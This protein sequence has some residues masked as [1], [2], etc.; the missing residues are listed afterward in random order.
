MPDKFFSIRQR[1]GIELS[2]QEIDEEYFLK[3]EW[4]KYINQQQNLQ[5]EQ[6]Q[7]ALKTQE[8]ALQELK[9]D[10]FNFYQKAIQVQTKA[11]LRIIK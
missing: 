5:M 4:K 3:K 8:H 6:I 10:N 9:A 2:K 1:T 11:I 7:R